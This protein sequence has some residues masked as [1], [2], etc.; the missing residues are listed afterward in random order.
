MKLPVL[1]F[2]LGSSVLLAGCATPDD[3]EPE[4]PTAET[5]ELTAEGVPDV[6]TAG[7]EFTFDLT[8]DGDLEWT[9]DHIG[10][11]FG[12]NSTDEP[13]T[14]KYEKACVHQAGDLPGEFEVTCTLHH[15][16]VWYLRGH[17]RITL[18]GGEQVNY[19]T[20][21]EYLVTAT[22]GDNETMER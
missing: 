22:P 9:S 14:T 20:D 12:M 5:Y 16:G 1:A 3:D 6:A 4:T 15:A 21:R 2:L 19:W 18:D 8:V 7:Q 17:T 13:S 10:G 11:H